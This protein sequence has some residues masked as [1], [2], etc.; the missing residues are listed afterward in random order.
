MGKGVWTFLNGYLL[1]HHFG[2]H[3]RDKAD[4]ELPDDLSGDDC[5]GTSFREGPFNTVE[6]EGGVPP[7]VHQDLLLQTEESNLHLTANNHYNNTDINRV[8]H[9]RPFFCVLTYWVEYC[10]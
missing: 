7:A 5:L 1:L 9:K 6:R 2:V 4:G 8:L 3:V 10:V